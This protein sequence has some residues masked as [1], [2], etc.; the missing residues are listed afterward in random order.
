M[1]L[2][3]L[4]GIHLG[5]NVEDVGAHVASFP[6]LRVHVSIV[7]GAGRMVKFLVHVHTMETRPFSP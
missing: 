1:H 6:G 7:H 2:A 4:V 3:Q 5:L